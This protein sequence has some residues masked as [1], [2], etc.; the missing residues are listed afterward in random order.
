MT[1]AERINFLQRTGANLGKFHILEPDAVNVSHEHGHPVG[2]ILNSDNIVSYKPDTGAY[3][4]TDSSI[5]AGRQFVDIF[6]SLTQ[7][8]PTDRIIYTARKVPD[9]ILAR[10]VRMNA[11]LQG[12]NPVNRLLD[13]NNPL[14][15]HV[16]ARGNRG[17]SRGRGRGR[18]N[19]TPAEVVVVARV[20][21][22]LVVLAVVVVVAAAAIVTAHTTEPLGK[23]IKRRRG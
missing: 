13:P 17:S 3:G 6:H 5:E 21:V 14:S 20:D 2:I 15:P 9:S 1:I 7:A 4:Q 18:G 23:R 12:R 19:S 8:A 10:Q 16:P 22:V 11:D